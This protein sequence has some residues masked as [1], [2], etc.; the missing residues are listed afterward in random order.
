ML[1]EKGIYSQRAERKHQ[2]LGLL[3]VVSYALYIRCPK[4]PFTARDKE[5]K[6]ASQYITSR[7][8]CPKGVSLREKE[9]SGP[10][11]LW[12]SPLRGDKEAAFFSKSPKGSARKNSE[13]PLGI[14]CLS[15]LRG[16]SNVPLWAYI[17]SPLRGAALPK[18]AKEGPLAFA[19]SGAALLY[20]PAFIGLKALAVFDSEGPLQR[21]PFG[22]RPF[23]LA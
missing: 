14:Y 3:V 2:P 17:A 7:L 16:D 15:P 10:K 20:M 9:Q 4:R 6:G 11:A 23:F 19:P 13:G 1:E 22:F 12:L 8:L 18:G 21:G 5:A